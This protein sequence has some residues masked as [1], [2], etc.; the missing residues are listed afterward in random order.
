MWQK[1]LI[2]HLSTLLYDIVCNLIRFTLL[3][4][5]KLQFSYARSDYQTHRI[6]RRFG[7]GQRPRSVTFGTVHCSLSAAIAEYL[8][9]LR[10]F[11]R[12][13]AA[14][15]AICWGGLRCETHIGDGCNNFNANVAACSEYKTREG[16]RAIR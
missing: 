1:V 12:L 7:E 14:M 4:T 6:F 9:F 13:H 8:F 10:I 16:R 3:R 15:F 5:K 2:G 11:A